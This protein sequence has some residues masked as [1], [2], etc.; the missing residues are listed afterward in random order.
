[1]PRALPVLLAILTLVPAFA[2]RYSGPRPPKPDMPYLLHASKLVPTEIGNAHEEKS[3]KDATTYIVDGA[4]SSAR[5]P[6]PEPIFIMES[7][8]IQ[9][10]RL[11]LYRFDVRNG[12]REVTMTQ[13]RGRNSSKQLFLNVTR[14]G[15]G[16]YRIESSQ[17]L[18]PG[19][20]SLSPDSSNQ[21]F[22]FSVY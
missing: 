13:K 6:V 2:D 15:D 14:L 9:A 1:M 7:Q 8:N 10:E 17:I 11:G 16:L 5:T 4:S 19:E 22:C 18:E 20:Y 21:V 12:R 3:K